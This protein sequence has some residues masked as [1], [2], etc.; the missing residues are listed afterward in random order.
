MTGQPASGYSTRQAAYD[1]KKF[2]G[3]ALVAKVGASRRYQ[4][5]PHAMRASA[6]LLILRQHV[7]APILAGVRSPHLGRKPKVWTIADRQYEQLRIG[8][9]PLFRARIAT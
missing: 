4:L 8:M 3:K 5:H 7:I 2:R 1:L 9:Q 6:A